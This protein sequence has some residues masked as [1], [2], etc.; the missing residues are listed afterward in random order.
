MACGVYWSSSTL[1]A[2][3]GVRIRRTAASAS[4]PSSAGNRPVRAVCAQSRITPRAC[5]PPN[6]QPGQTP[7]S[8]AVAAMPWVYGSTP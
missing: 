8:R 3:T 2:S 6:P 7:S 1:T 4:T 5:R